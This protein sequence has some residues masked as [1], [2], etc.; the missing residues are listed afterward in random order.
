L[1]LA[2]VLCLDLGEKRCGIA[3]SD[4]SRRLATPLKVLPTA[5]VEG[6]AASF[7]RLLEDYEPGLLLCGLPLSMDASS[8]AQAER[9]RDMAQ[10]IAARHGL[11]L[12]FSDERLSTAQ[13]KRALHEAGMDERR[14]RGRVDA[15]AACII[16][17]SWLDSE[18]S[19]PPA[20]V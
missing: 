4:A 6:A 11:A 5:E 9:I 7:R 16:L 12:R 8:G 20:A 2:R 3:V 18:S 10:R 13:A 1:A 15:V 19:A 14:M 17:Q